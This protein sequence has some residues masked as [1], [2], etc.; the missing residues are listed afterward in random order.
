MGCRAG[1]YAV[2]QAAQNKALQPLGQQLESRADRGCISRNAI[3]VSYTH[4]DVYKRQDALC[5]DASSIAMKGE[6]RPLS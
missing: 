4:L 6:T 3:P 5:H 2:F 1:L